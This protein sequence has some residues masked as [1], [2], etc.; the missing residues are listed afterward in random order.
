[1][2]SIAYPYELRTRPLPRL[3]RRAGFWA[4]AF[5][6]LALTAFATAPSALYG[7]YAASEHLSPITLTF[8]Y[9]VYAVGVV[10][11]RGRAGAVNRL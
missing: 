2:N 5:A 7:F 10:A 9:A 11:R 4:V 6:F 3:S 8:V 1:M